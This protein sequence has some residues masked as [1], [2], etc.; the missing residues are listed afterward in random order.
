MNLLYPLF[1]AASSVPIGD[2]HAGYE[3]ELIACGAKPI[4]VIDEALAE[5]PGWK[6]IPSRMDIRNTQQRAIADQA[7]AQGKILKYKLTVAPPDLCPLWDRTQTLHF[8]CQPQFKDDMME[9]VEAYRNNLIHGEFGA[10]S[11]ESGYYFGCTDTDFKHPVEGSAFKALMF[12]SPVTRYCRA[13]ALKHE[14][15]VGTIRLR[16]KPDP[17]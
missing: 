4:A 1:K 2:P 5:G 15:K 3:G 6:L 16:T 12:I 8:Y 7:V 13:Q 14:A 10:L 17:S 9:L 11:R